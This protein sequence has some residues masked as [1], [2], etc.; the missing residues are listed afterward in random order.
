MS[1]PDRKGMTLDCL[2]CLSKTCLGW[3]FSISKNWLPGR[4]SLSPERKMSKQ[5][6][7]QKIKNMIN[8]SSGKKNRHNIPNVPEILTSWQ[9]TFFFSATESDFG[10]EAD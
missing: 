9:H 3:A 6:N 10:K 5:R 1:E 2:V 8:A 7:I 4:V